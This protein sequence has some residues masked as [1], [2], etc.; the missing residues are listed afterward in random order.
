[1]GNTTCVST[2]MQ[3]LHIDLPTLINKSMK[4]RIIQLQSLVRKYLKRKNA[5]RILWTTHSVNWDTAFKNVKLNLVQFDERYI[6]ENLCYFIYSYYQKIFSLNTNIKKHIIT[7]DDYNLQEPYEFVKNFRPLIIKFMN[8]QFY[9]GRYRKELKDLS[10]DY[11]LDD[12]LLEKLGLYDEDYSIHDRMKFLDDTESSG[13]RNETQIHRYSYVQTR[14]TTELFKNVSPPRHTVYANRSA[15]GHM[16][17]RSEQKKQ[18]KKLYNS[19]FKDNLVLNKVKIAHEVSTKEEEFNNNTLS[20]KRSTL[21][22][23]NEYMGR[24]KLFDSQGNMVFHT[25]MEDITLQH[26]IN[27]YIFDRENGQFYKGGWN[28]KAKCKD[29]FA[30]QYSVNWSYGVRYKYMGYFKNNKFHGYG[31]IIR[32]DGYTYQG[33]FRDGKQSGFGI[34][35][36][37]DK[38]YQGFFYENVYHGYGELTL[39]NV[40]RYKGCFDMGIKT[41]IG[42]TQNEDGSR[43]IGKY[44]NGKIYDFGAFL[45]K[46]GHIYYGQFKNEKMEGRGK[47][48]WLNGDIF[49]GTYS[50]D[51]K[52]G[53]GEYYFAD[54]NSILRGSWVMGKK[55]GRFDLFKGGEKF[56]IIYKKDQQIVL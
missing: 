47:F 50:K 54:Q 42:L 32:E 23:K 9:L 5:M 53:D 38:V 2:C 13:L 30:V 35:I 56:S 1:M 55:D 48:K 51:L 20:S 49:V 3:K 21:N 40:V 19:F 52:N 26:C 12:N 24:V 34:E 11:E 44:H 36:I 46:E 22:T 43:F 8:K 17:L 6:K 10:I 41:D 31:V 7:E 37:N 18:T 27:V 4:E 16:P 45:Y 28:I 39:K 25:I 15:A 29:G 33:E 14:Q